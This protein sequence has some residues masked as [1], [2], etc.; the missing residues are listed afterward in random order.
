MQTLPLATGLILTF[1]LANSASAQSQ[2]SPD[3]A[4][5][6]DQITGLYSFE[7]HT[8]SSE[9]RESKSSQLDFFWK[10]VEANPEKYLPL[11][12]DELG[13]GNNSAFF[14][15]DGSKLLLSISEEREDR[16]LALESIPKANLN[17]IQNTDY[18]KTVH[19]LASNGFDT[20]DAAL[21]ILD[22][23]E[24]Q[25]FIVQ[26]V[27]TLGQDYSLIYMLFPMP[28]ANFVEALISRLGS[29]E[30]VQSQQ[31]ILLALWYAV[32]PDAS[33]AMEE[34]AADNSKPLEARDF[35]RQLVENQAST[36]AAL[37]VSETEGLKKKR[38]KVMTRL[39]DEALIEFDNITVELLSQQ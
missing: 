7:P 34:F 2:I 19:W 9:Q 24:F 16:A 37:S 10:M 35:A 30:N 11:L 12:R 3:A 5:F 28:D 1:A 27:L 6:H 21:R 29:E 26:H 15:Y 39:S 8:L 17:S 33:A 18:L 22:Y 23:P 4:D 20:T 36:V 38:R 14:S 32:D 13:T 31:S 25:A